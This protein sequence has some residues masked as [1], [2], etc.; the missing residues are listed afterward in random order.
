MREERFT[1]VP[2][3]IETPKRMNGADMDVRNLEILRALASG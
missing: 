3:I 2:K 1:E